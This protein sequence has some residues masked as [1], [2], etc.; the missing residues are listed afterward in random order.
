M[1]N[2]IKVRL[3]SGKLARGTGRVA[4]WVGGGVVIQ[5]DQRTGKV[6]CYVLPGSKK[7]SKKC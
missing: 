2:K 1:Q 6:L 4:C 3:G 5:V 7:T